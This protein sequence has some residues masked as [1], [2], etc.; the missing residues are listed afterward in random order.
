MKTGDKVKCIKNDFDGKQL[1]LTIGKW[2]KIEDET[3]Y[4]NK[5]RYWITND[6]GSLHFFWSHGPYRKYLLSVK[7][8]RKIKLEKLN[9]SDET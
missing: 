7:D 8:E 2:Y 9:V 1:K 5:C 3:T 6:N 4:D